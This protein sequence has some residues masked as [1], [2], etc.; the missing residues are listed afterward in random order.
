MYV[1]DVFG[2]DGCGTTYTSPLYLDKHAKYCRGLKGARLSN[3]IVV[4]SVKCSYSNSNDSTVI[5]A[6]RLR[7][8]SGQDNRHSVVSSHAAHL[9]TSDGSDTCDSK[10]LQNSV[11]SEC[12]GQ[13]T[14]Q[15]HLTGQQSAHPSC[16]NAYVK[17]HIGESS[18]KDKQY[19]QKC[20]VQP[21]LFKQQQ[22]VHTGGKPYVCTE[23]GYKC[24]YK[25]YMVQHS[26][27]H[28]GEKP[29]VCTECGDKF[30]QKSHLVQHSRIHTGEK[31][32]VCTECGD[33]FTQKNILVRHSRIHTGEKPY[34]C[35]ECGDKFTHKSSLVWH[36][37]I[38]TGGILVRKKCG[39]TFT[40]RFNLIRHVGKKC[41]NKFAHKPNHV[42]HSTTHTK[43]EAHSHINTPGEFSKLN[44]LQSQKALNLTNEE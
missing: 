8:C 44:A 43:A 42:T 25:W 38:H 14:H 27:I 36:S 4:C 11:L 30:T 20:A 13:K 41:D 18:Y 9:D 24:T 6:N 35:T 37:R 16:P 22:T 23:C 15:G 33:K 2:C 28:T 17:K 34:V 26:R 10:C 5:C 1:A 19:R 31:P 32:Y 3:G 12:D 29:Y 39:D 7:Q 21:S 40:N